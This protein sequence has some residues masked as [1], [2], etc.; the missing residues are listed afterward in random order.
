MVIYRKANMITRKSTV[1]DLLSCQPFSRCKEIKNNNTKTHVKQTFKKN[2]CIV[3]HSNSSYVFCLCMVK[4]LNTFC[5]WEVVQFHRDYDTKDVSNFFLILQ[6]FQVRQP[7]WVLAFCQQYQ[8]SLNL[9]VLCLNWYTCS[10][11][12]LV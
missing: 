9:F 7:F 12:L 4:D 5:S 2:L 10:E 3:I 1:V 6:G 8:V 11:A